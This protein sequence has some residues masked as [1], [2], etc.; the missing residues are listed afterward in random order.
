M[1]RQQS[2]ATRP[3]QTAYEAAVAVV[4]EQEG[5][6]AR[7]SAERA[8]AE[9]ELEDLQTRIGDEVLADESAAEGLAGSMARLRDRIDIAG[10]AAEAAKPKVLA[11]RRAAALLDAEAWDAEAARRRAVLA[12]HQARTDKLLAELE[13]HECKFVTEQQWVH[14][15]AAADSGGGPETWSVPK[16]AE[17]VAAVKEAELKAAI[18]REVVAGGDPRS[19]TPDGS[20]SGQGWGSADRRLAEG[21]FP[22]SVWGP[23]AVLPAPWHV[24]RHGDRR[25]PAEV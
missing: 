1:A 18:I 9:A 3:T 5:V 10:R 12:V 11:A 20:V 17:I 14:A 16:S 21:D 13:E 24:Q 6:L 15:L 25:I 22:P 19:V 2:E 4:R 8:T 23:E 7:W